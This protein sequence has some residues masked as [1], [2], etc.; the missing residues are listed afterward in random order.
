MNKHQS[1]Y[2]R[3][4]AYTQRKIN[5][6]NVMS[7]SFN[8]YDNI[9]VLN[10]QQVSAHIQYALRTKLQ[11]SNHIPFK[12]MNKI[13]HKV[14]NMPQLANLIKGQVLFVGTADLQHLMSV[15]SAF[16]MIKPIVGIQNSQL[17]DKDILITSGKYNHTQM[18]ALIFKQIEQ[19]RQKAILSIFESFNEQ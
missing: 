7:D 2:V 12:I 10:V 1:K 19:S 4:N 17:I 8:K 18:I 13:A 3:Q 14:F 5:N 11:N 15:V 6:L 16:N 9:V